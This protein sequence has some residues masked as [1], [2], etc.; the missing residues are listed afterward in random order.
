MK[1]KPDKPDSA[2]KKIN[3]CLRVKVV[4]D[5][6]MSGGWQYAQVIREVCGGCEKRE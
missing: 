5:Q 3:G 4:L 6:E 2:C 1:R